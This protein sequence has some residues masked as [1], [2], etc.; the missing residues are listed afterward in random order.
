MA[1][2][3]SVESRSQ[4]RSIAENLHQ[5]GVQALRGGAFK[6][7]K[8]PHTFSGLGEEG[9]KILRSVADEFNLLIITE[10]RSVENISLVAEKSNI[11]QID[12]RNLHHY[13]LLWAAGE[14]Q[15]PILLKRGFM[16]TVEK[17]VLAAEHY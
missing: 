11:I 9:R 4:T 15:R 3:C 16:S 10:P 5:F 14:T 6:P 8:S 7:R 1:G 12:S 2:P 13:P 17:W